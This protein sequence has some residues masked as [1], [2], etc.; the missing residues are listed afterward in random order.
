MKTR[1]L[2]ID[3]QKVIGEYIGE[4]L[5][6]KAYKVGDKVFLLCQ[7]DYSKECLALFAD[8]SLRHV[9][10]IERHEDIGDNQVFSMPYYNKLTKKEYPQAFA[11]WRKL[12]NG[13]GISAQGPKAI[14]ALIERLR[15]QGEQSLADAV[16][17]MYEAFQNYAYHSI[18]FEFQKVNVS[19]NDKGELI[20]RDC[21]ADS[22]SINKKRKNKKGFAL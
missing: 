1:E 15:I 3:G 10:T 11:Q 17:N 8:Q 22:E 19:V 16:S 14:E 7:G 9:P 12:Q 20:L 6:S 5:F 21:L 2:T 13:L 4:G 18:V